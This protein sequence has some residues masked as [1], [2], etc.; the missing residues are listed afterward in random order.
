MWAKK[1]NGYLSQ[2]LEVFGYFSKFYSGYPPEDAAQ[3]L[4]L[5]S[6]N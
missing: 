2:G 1:L 6:K 3:M 5:L 4:N